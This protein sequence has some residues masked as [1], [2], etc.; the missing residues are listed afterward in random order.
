VAVQ[1]SDVVA[2]AEVDG[3]DMHISL[4]VHSRES[5]ER[6]ELLVIGPQTP[7]KTVEIIAGTTRQQ[8]TVP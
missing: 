6:G 8:V 7:S 5:V 3:S 4:V 2:L 1:P